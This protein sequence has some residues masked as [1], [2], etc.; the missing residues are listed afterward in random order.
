M[1][2]YIL[3]NLLL[4]LLYVY[5][6]YKLKHAEHMFQLESYKPER[7]FKW[8]KNNKTIYLKELL[9]LI[10][11]VLVFFNKT[12]GLLI[13][14]VL[15]VFLW[16]TRKKYIEKK[17]LV[18]TNRIK[19]MDVTEIIIFLII[20]IIANFKLDLIAI[21]LNIFIIFSYMF[22]LIIHFI[23]SP[24]EKSIQK[25][26]YKRA[27]NKL[28]DNSN[29]K[30]V[31]VTGSYGKT[32]TKYILGTILEQKFNT[33]IT[34]ESYNTTMG[35]VR[36][37]NEKLNNTHEVFVCEMGAKNIGDIEEICELVNPTY[38]VLTAIGPQHLETFKT[39]ENVQKTKLELIDSLPEKEGIAF[40]NYEDKNIVNSK[41]NK[42]QIKFGL[43]K[44]CDYYADNIFIDENGSNFDVHTKNAEI[45][46]VKT[47]LLGRHNILNIVG[48]VAVASELGV[49]VPQIKA[50]IRFLKPVMH[51]L[52][53]KKNPNGSIIIDDAYN[54]NTTRSKNG[55]RGFRRFYK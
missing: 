32:S 21:V 50:G 13:N 20:A 33:L 23:N 16:F 29:L 5:W 26:F 36:T 38:G 4:V 54:S 43:N 18:N 40:I 3:L 24:I 15:L 27:K 46:S 47:K 48:A 31:G 53:L 12:V 52:E 35:V 34:P 55:T 30:V 9:L 8:A 10:P 22:L 7:Y 14:I 17:P 45:I 28:K 2:N 1:I 11:T 19:R 41:I 51:R 25:K 37:I 44:N 42:N 6:L 39:L 49:S